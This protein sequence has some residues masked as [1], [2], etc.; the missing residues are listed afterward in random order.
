MMR[1]RL[2]E[3]GHC[4]EKDKEYS[5]LVA[6]FGETEMIRVLETDYPILQFY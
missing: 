5:N 6:N 4:G 3:E 2:Y 1:C